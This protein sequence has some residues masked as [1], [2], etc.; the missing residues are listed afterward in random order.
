MK[1]II[2][3]LI[4]FLIFKFSYGQKYTVSFAKGNFVYLEVGNTL[5]V[6]YE[7]SYDSLFLVTNNGRIEAF[8]NHS[9][10]WYPANLSTSKTK[11]NLSLYK[12]LKNDTIFIDDMFFKIV[13]LDLPVIGIQGK[14]EGFINKDLLVKGK[15]LTRFYP[16]SFFSEDPFRALK[17]V[18]FSI[19]INRDDSIIYF[20]KNK[21]FQFSE[22][23]ML[24]F[25][26]LQKGDRIIIFHVYLQY[27]DTI[28]NLKPNELTVE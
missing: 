1:T 13:K 18:E 27:K 25:N 12:I 2:I 4:L 7:G 19:A 23:D 9:Y 3:L 8:T 22:K 14:H 28:I 24:M 21:S 11:S 15:G 10:T 5:D 26:S 16:N 6:S 20:N 17:I